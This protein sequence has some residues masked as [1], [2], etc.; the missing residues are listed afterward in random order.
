MLDID[1]GDDY[2]SCVTATSTPTIQPPSYTPKKSL[3]VSAEI[4]RLLL[5][6]VTDT[7]HQSAI[8]I[9]YP[10]FKITII[11]INIVSNGYICTKQQRAHAHNILYTNNIKSCT[12]IDP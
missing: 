8:I 4:L 5:I 3:T 1:G 10:I 7:Q 11:T 12:Y 6:E 9:V 2:H